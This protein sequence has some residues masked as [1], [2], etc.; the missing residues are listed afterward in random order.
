MIVVCA[1]MYRAGSTWQYQI[2]NAVLTA[3]GRPVVAAGHVEGDR[4]PG[5][6]AGHRD[7]SEWLVLKAHDTHPAFDRELD[8]GRAVGLYCYRDLRDVVYSMADKLNGGFRQAVD[9][10]RVLD[11]SLTNDAAW[12]FRPGVLVQRY[13]ERLADDRPAVAEIA[14][15]LKVTLSMDEVAGIAAEFGLARNRE[16]TDRLADRLRTDGVDL[17]DPRNACRYDPGSLLH[18]NHVRDGRAGGWR[19]RATPDELAVLRERC[20]GWLIAR[21]YEPDDR[22]AK[23]G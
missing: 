10:F 6:R 16:R 8:A 13:E 19:R 22:W 4:F 11:R 12:P 2:A 15:H 23:A 20:G 5:V 3:A 7:E 17:S 21:G 9:E 1:G 18:W 14:R